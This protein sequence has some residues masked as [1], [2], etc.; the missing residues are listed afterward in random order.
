[1]SRVPRPLPLQGGRERPA[2]T[3]VLLREAYLALNDQVIV[4]L[5]GRG[6]EQVRPAHGAVF[7]HLDDTGTTVSRLAERAQMTKQAMAEL[8]AHLEKHGYVERRADPDDRRAKLV[9][10]TERGRAV[11]AIAQSLVPDVEGQL[12]DLLGPRRV[13]QLRDDLER[14]RRL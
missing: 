6:H 2:N 8:V 10:P 7:Q 4:R 3:V 9:V 1:M 13:A 12:A 5:A 14:I 11:L